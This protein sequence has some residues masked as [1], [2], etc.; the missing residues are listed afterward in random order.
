M[1]P[2]TQAAFHAALDAL[3]TAPSAVP[4]V[5]II[6]DAGLRGEV[7]AEEGGGGAMW[8]RKEV[9]DV[10]SVLSR[11]LLAGPYVTQIAFIGH[12]SLT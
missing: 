12:Q 11:D 7:G 3:T 8:A 2:R 6:S 9:L 5:L 1:H 10:R 4:I